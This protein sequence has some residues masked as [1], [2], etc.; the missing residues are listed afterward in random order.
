MCRKSLASLLGVSCSQNNFHV[1]KTDTDLRS[2][3][4]MT[5]LMRPLTRIPCRTP[6]QQLNRFLAAKNVALDKTNIQY[7]KNHIVGCIIKLLCLGWCQH[8]IIFCPVIARNSTAVAEQD[9][10][11]VCPVVVRVKNIWPKIR[12]VGS[13]NTAAL[14]PHSA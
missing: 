13:Y 12:V 7:K 11:F 10:S 14:A 5:T 8:W 1:Q 4:L 3:L 6:T 2:R 9:L